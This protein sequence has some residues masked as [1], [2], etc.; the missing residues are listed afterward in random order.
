M[1]KMTAAAL[2]TGFAM[3]GAAW[4]VRGRSSTAFGHSVHH[5]HTGRKSIALTFDDGPAPSTP[6][7][8]D[9]LAEYRIPAT[10]FQIG[11]NVLKHPDIARAVLAAGHE[12]GN[13]SHTHLNFALRSPA[14]IEDDFTR[15]QDA[16]GDTTG[17]RPTLMRAPYGVRWFGF[18]RMQAKLG[19]TGVMWTVIGLDWKLPAA[20]IAERVLSHATP[21]GIVCLHD[22]RDTRANPDVTPALEAV[23]R[24]VPALIG[25]GYHF[26]SVS[27][28]L[29]PQI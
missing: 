1:Q 26:E 21:G 7:F 9:V 20:A 19:L 23:R 28:L 10:F 3:A 12:L 5:G 15:A 4:A 22:G 6:A 2:A 27:Q 17:L 25:A 11:S 13:H 24:I 8:L 16:I 18:R 14:L 29:C